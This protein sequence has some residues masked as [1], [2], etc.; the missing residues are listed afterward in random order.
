[1]QATTRVHD[2]LANAVLQEADLVL[3]HPV[4]FHPT[5]GL[6]NTD[7]DG[8][9]RTIGCFRLWGD[10]T[11]TRFF[12]GLDDR[13]PLARKTLEP[14]ILIEITPGGESIAC[15]VREACIMRLALVGVAQEAPVTGLIDHQEGF[16][17]V[18][19]LLA[20]GVFLLFLR[21]GWAVD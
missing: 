8:R 16:D 19:L 15:Q 18:A 4:S 17:R 12:L 6:C 7:A 10:F 20:T 5:D 3:D 14:G 11:P 13:D 21:I 9:D 1:M 2:G